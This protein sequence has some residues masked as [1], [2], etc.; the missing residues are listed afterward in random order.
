MNCFSGKGL[1]MRMDATAVGNWQA[2]FEQLALQIGSCFARGDLR[3]R[4]TAYVRGLLGPVQRKNGWQLAE[5]L[6]DA[7]PHG[8]QR[9]LDRAR[10][11]AD[12]LRDEL[13]R[14]A[15]EHLLTEGDGGVLIVDETGFLKKGDKSV[16][17][18]RQ[19]SGT[20][21]RIENCQIG[22]FLA[23]AGP[24]GRALIDRELYLPKS[25]CD[26]RGRCREAHVPEE[27]DFATKPKL[28]MRMIDRAWQ[29]G[30]RPRWVLGDEVYGSDS[31]LRRFLDEHGQPYV[32]AVSGQQRLWQDLEQQRVDTIA[33]SIPSS[34]WLRLSLADGSKGPRVYDWAAGQFGIATEHGLIHWLLIRRGLDDPHEQAYYLCAAPPQATAHDLAIAAGQRWSIECCF[35]SAKQ[36]TGLDNYEVR[37]WH[38]W[39]RHVT[40]SMLAL[41]LLAVIRAAAG[42]DAK[43]SQKRRRVIWSH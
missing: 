12:G 43:P 28:A 23:L 30:I 3:R 32:L 20:A 41:A 15:C 1:L 8:V 5:H 22:V 33:R 2:H 6:G 4:A 10:W 36:E 34:S 14:Y 21:G 7:T 19:Y 25:W 27:V 17:V 18:Q 31:K 16:G 11:D 26:D 39:H 9:L 24:R 40:L 37:N 38:G 35:E 42:P 29:A 13:V